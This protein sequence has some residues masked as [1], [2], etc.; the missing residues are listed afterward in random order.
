MTPPPSLVDNSLTVG[1][2]HESNQHVV[3]KDVTTDTRSRALRA[4]CWAV[5]VG[6]QLL[7][8]LD[9]PELLGRL[10]GAS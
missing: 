6:V 2:L 7:A 3:L 8:Q 4:P 1:S 10:L 9:L 5:V